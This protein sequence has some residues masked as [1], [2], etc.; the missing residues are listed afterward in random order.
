[1]TDIPEIKVTA[2]KNGKWR[3]DLAEGGTRRFGDRAGAI[4]CAL[5][6]KQPHESVRLYRAD[7]SLS[8]ELAHA[9]GY[10]GSGGQDVTL[11][12]AGEQSRAGR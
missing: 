8:G 2:Q 4:A 5:E 12:P 3:V 6:V 7:G 10:G 1:M 11:Q 9:E